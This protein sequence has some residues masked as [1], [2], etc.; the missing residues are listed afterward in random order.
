VTCL[1]AKL[2][3]TGKISGQ[4]DLRIDGKVDGPVWL[5]GYRLTV[6]PTGQLNSDVTASEIVVQGKI[7]GNLR[8]LDRVD[9]K[10]GG[11]VVGDV[12]TA[13]ISIEDGADFKGHAEIERSKA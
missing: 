9:I 3:V 2:E 5:Q 7:T 6:G 11:S 13:R 1:S 12:T 4:E 8:A 10:H